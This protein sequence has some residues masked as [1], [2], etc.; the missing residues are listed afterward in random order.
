FACPFR[1]HDPQ[2]YSIHSHRVCALT[3]WDT[4]A[5]VK[6]HL[7]RI[8]KAA[9]YCKRCW[10]VFES[11]ELLDSHATVPAS[12]ICEAMPGYPPEGV[13]PKQVAEL[14]SKAKPYSKQ[15]EA[16][17]WK[18]IFRLL[19]P[20]ATVPSPYWEQIQ[21]HAPSSPYSQVLASYEAYL[22]RE[23]PRLFRSR[24]EEVVFRE[25]QPVEANILAN[26]ERLIRECQDQLSSGYRETQV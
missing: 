16:D 7:Y 23:L 9:P 15:N 10:K 24:V 4:I 22:H 25:M 21:D 14:R 1:K 2:K 26:L 13:T 5:R 11:E 8:H 6:E 3:S 17:R 19:F 12:S 18:E 20:G